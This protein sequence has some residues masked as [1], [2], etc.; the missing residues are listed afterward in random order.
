ML[1]VM[2]ERMR[3][4][5]DIN[6]N[7]MVILKVTMQTACRGQCFINMRQRIMSSDKYGCAC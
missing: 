7:N 1:V 2:K 5:C 4:V 3:N 6:I